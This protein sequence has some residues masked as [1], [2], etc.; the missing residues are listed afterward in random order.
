METAVEAGARREA[1]NVLV[2][3]IVT[4]VWVASVALAQFGPELLWGEQPVLSWIA[5]ALNLVLGIAW[6]VVH[7]R[8][9]GG[10]DELQRKILMDAMAVALGVGLVGGF[11]WASAE[12]AGLVE[13]GSDIALL[14]VVLAVVYLVS[15][16]VGRLRYR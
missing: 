8:Y 2:L 5:I 6:I 7:A 12:S 13:V 16:V 10:V 3:A 11:A 14:S 15:I 9:L 1:R 4:M